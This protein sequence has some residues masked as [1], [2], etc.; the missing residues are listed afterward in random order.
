MGS[1]SSA[2]G[3][4]RPSCPLSET[5]SEVA[6]QPPRWAPP[7]PSPQD[8]RQSRLRCPCQPRRS[9]AGRSCCTR[10]GRTRPSTEPSCRL[11]PCTSARRQAPQPPMSSPS[12]AHGPMR[13]AGASHGHPSSPTPATPAPSSTGA[14]SAAAWSSTPGS[15]SPRFGSSS[16]DRTASRPPLLSQ[17]PSAGPATARWSSSPTARSSTLRTSPTPPGARTSSSG[18]AMDARPSRRPRAS[19]RGAPSTT[20]LS[21]PR[22][23]TSPRSRASPTRR[24][25]SRLPARAATLRHPPAPGSLPSSTAAPAWTTPSDRA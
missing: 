4:R 13:P 10:R 9:R 24:P 3:N 11:P 8:R 6:S 5:G 14:T 17:A 21:T 7:S 18:W 25:C 19:T 12:P 15:T 1:A 16:P 23:R 2:D 20:C 22:P